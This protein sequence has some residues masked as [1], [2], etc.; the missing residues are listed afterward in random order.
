M[1]QIRLW[2]AEKGRLD[3]QTEITRLL[4]LRQ[5]RYPTDRRLVVDHKLTYETQGPRLTV[6]SL[7]LNRP[8]NQNLS[9]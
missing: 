9:R 3:L 8:E 5:A 2:L 6:S 1:N 7:D 4:E